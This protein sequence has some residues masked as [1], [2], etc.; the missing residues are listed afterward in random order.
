M[1]P[2]YIGDLDKYALTAALVNYAMERGG[3]TLGYVLDIELAR[4]FVQVANKGKLALD[5]VHGVSIYVDLTGDT[6]D[7]TVYDHRYGAG[8]AATVVA[9]VRALGY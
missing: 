5:L 2:N 1:G 8:A 3:V 9:R 7:P 4:T 6:L